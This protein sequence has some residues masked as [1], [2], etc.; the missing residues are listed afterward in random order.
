[1]TDKGQELKELCEKYGYKFVAGFSNGS[2]DFLHFKND[3]KSLELTIED[4]FFHY[5]ISTIY[6]K[7]TISIYMAESIFNEDTFKRKEMIL[8][9]LVNPKDDV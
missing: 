5:H 8:L 9:N 7:S 4:I 2:G 6:K 1:M 3:E